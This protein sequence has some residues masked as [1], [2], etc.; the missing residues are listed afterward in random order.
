MYDMKPLTSIC[1]RCKL[2]WTY[3]PEVKAKKKKSTSRLHDAPN[4]VRLIFVCK[5]SYVVCFCFFWGLGY[6]FLA[7]CDSSASVALCTSFYRHG[8]VNFAA[9]S[10]VWIDWAYAPKKYS[11]QSLRGA[12]R[13]HWMLVVGCFWLLGLYQWPSFDQGVLLAS[14]RISTDLTT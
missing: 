2:L 5:I 7:V 4:Q 12:C 9:S 14:T 13:S 6:E 10:D 3:Q 8:A 11:H 1:V